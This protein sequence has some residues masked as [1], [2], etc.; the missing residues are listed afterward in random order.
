MAPGPPELGSHGALIKNTVPRAPP[1]IYWLKAL[2]D[3]GPRK[4]HFSHL[5]G[6]YLRITREMAEQRARTGSSL[7][8]CPCPRCSSTLLPT[9]SVRCGV[10]YNFRERNV[11]LCPNNPGKKSH[12]KRAYHTDCSAVMLFSQPDF[13]FSVHSTGSVSRNS[14]QLLEIPMKSLGS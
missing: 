9:A 13:C 6:D 4:Q 10:A 12:L 3:F 1:E 11:Y 5:P 14:I 7:E 8:I 2:W